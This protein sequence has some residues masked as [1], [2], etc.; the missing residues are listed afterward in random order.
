[1]DYTGSV[2]CVPW[3]G[4]NCAILVLTK[5]DDWTKLAGGVEFTVDGTTGMDWGLELDWN[6]LD[7][8]GLD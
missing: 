1:M 8:R 7:R 3:T 6:G 2:A 4:L 5:I